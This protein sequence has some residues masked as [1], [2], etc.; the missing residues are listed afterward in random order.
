MPYPTRYVDDFLRYYKIA[1]R[2]EERNLR[3]LAGEQD[4]YVAPDPLMENVLIYNNVHRRYA[5]FSKVLEDIHGR[6]PDRF[7]FDCSHFNDYT[8]R[9]LELV[10]RVTGSGASFEKD[11]GYRNAIVPRLAATYTD[12][13]DMAAY[14]EHLDT[15]FDGVRPP[16]FTSIGNQ[17]PPFPKPLSPFNSGGFMYLAR[18]APRL[19]IDYQS[20]LTIS[21]AERQTP[22]DQRVATDWVLSWHTKYGLKKFHFV[23]TAWVMDTA[24]Y[25][26]EY[27]SR[28]SLVYYGKN[29]LECLAL[30][31]KPIGKEKQSQANDE[32]VLW[33]CEQLGAYPYDLEDVLCDYIRYVE[34]YVPP[35]SYA[36]L[37]PEQKLNASLVQDHP[38]RLIPGRA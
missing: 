24:E 1:L 8:W 31:F 19:A 11:H 37:E 33:L 30:L 13:V 35:G 28:E 38:K 18:Y 20:W 17:I 9:Y 23:L 12:L 16:I 6:R 25:A 29:A 4:D 3:R 7:A 32:G 27:V 15:V 10:H 22:M 5:G 26:P 2:L 14:L 34:N 36:H 21:L